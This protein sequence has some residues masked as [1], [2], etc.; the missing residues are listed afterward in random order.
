MFSL[1]KLFDAFQAIANGEEKPESTVLQPGITMSASL[2]A[3]DTDSGSLSLKTFDEPAVPASVEAVAEQE[4]SNLM[5]DHIYERNG[6]R[7]RRGKGKRKAY[8]QALTSVAYKEAGEQ[9][10]ER[11][12][13]IAD[14][15]ALKIKERSRRDERRIRVERGMHGSAF[16]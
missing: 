13:Q 9:D 15:I 11:R 7:T 1:K 6:R 4:D 2:F 16:C 14:L 3:K 5:I 10:C 12:D 8:K